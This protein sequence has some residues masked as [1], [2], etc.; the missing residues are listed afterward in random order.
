MRKQLTIKVLERKFSSI[1]RSFKKKWGISAHDRMGVIELTGH[2]ENGDKA[3]KDFN[4]V[5]NQMEL[6]LELIEWVQKQNK[7]GAGK[8]RKPTP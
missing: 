4:K 5:V 2:K 8:T 3:L 6:L 1:D 7:K